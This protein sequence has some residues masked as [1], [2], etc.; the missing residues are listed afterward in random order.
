MNI[1]TL[2][3]RARNCD[4]QPDIS[5]SRYFTAHCK[6]PLFSKHWD[7]SKQVKSSQNANL[8]VKVKTMH[9]IKS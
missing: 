2:V 6:I 7:T 8:V 4:K 9:I 5:N 1:Y 3:P